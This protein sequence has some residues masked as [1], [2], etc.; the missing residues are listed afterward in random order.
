EMT[1]RGKRLDEQIDIIRAVL[2]GGYVEF[3][4]AHYDFDRLRM[5]PPA[6]AGERVP[7]YVGGHSDAGMRRAARTGDG[8]IGAQASAADLADLIDR[9]WSALDAAGRAEDPFEIKA[10][11]LV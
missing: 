8:W 4:G 1:T 11:P 9:L 3:H 7:I 2:S 6:P 5:E 10:T